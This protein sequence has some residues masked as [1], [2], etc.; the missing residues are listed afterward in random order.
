[1]RED[2]WILLTAGSN[3]VRARLTL[4]GSPGPWTRGTKWDRPGVGW[5]QGAERARGAKPEEL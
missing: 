1:M 4:S 2:A 5:G 3:F